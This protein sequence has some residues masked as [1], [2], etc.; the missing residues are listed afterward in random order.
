MA[1]HRA[2]EVSGHRRLTAGR[3]HTLAR[4]RYLSEDSVP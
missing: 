2:L 4:V 1:H 3:P